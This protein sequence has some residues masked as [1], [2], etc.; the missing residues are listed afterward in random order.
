MMLFLGVSAMNENGG[1]AITEEFNEEAKMGIGG[2]LGLKFAAEGC[3]VALFSRKIANVQ[4]LA[5]AIRGRGGQAICV[6]C[7]LSSEVFY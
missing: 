4:N 6:L 1:K 5:K 3:F 2:A 7:E